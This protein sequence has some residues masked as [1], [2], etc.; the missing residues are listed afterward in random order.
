LIDAADGTEEHIMNGVRELR[1]SAR[2]QIV[3]PREAREALELKPGDQILMAVREDRVILLRRPISFS[4]ALRG[5]S[6]G[7]YSKNYLRKERDTW[8][9][10]D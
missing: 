4:K 2:N 10:A 6:P 5:L 1:M 8:D 9:Q 3:L 7:L